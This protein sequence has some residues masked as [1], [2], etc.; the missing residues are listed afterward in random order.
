MKG[1]RRLVRHPRLQTVLLQITEK[2]DDA[3]EIRSML[4]EFQGAAFSVLKKVQTVPGLDAHSAIV[5]GTA[6]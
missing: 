5:A 1:A 3:E 2:S 4:A 6:A